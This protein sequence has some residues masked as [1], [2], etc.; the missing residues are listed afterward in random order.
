MKKYK[1]HIILNLIGTKEWGQRNGSL[2]VDFRIVADFGNY[3]KTQKKKQ[4]KCLFFADKQIRYQN[5][6][7]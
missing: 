4:T 1:L 7:L 6:N 2:V 3:S 5:E